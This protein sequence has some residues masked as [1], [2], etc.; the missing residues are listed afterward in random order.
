[1][2]QN[3]VDNIWFC[4][5][6]ASQPRVIVTTTPKPV[7]HIGSTGSSVPRLTRQLLSLEGRRWTTHCLP[8]HGCSA[9]WGKS[10]ALDELI[11]DYDGTRLGRQELHGELAARR[12]GCIVGDRL[13]THGRTGGMAHSGEA[14]GDGEDPG[15]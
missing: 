13:E 12:R 8:G 3:V 9:Q 5:R 1:M 6:E 11:R 7:S 2:A 10:G 14:V 15:Y 4:L